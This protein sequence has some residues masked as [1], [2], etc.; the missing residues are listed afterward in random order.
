MSRGKEQTGRR[1]SKPSKKNS[2]PPKK[3]KSKSRRVPS[4]MKNRRNCLRIHPVKK[5]SAKV[6]K[7]KIKEGFSKTS[8]A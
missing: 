4:G 6:N 7:K 2:K 8:S 5:S 1:N 3:N